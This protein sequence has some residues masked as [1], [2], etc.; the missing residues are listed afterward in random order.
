M[1]HFVYRVFSSVCFLVQGERNTNKLDKLYKSPLTLWTSPISR[2]NKHASGKCELHN[3]ALIAMENFLRNM[4][5]EAVPIHQQINNLLQRQISKNREI[6]KSLFKT[7]IF[8]QK[9]NI[10]LST[11]PTSSM[12]APNLN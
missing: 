2:F 1:V 8:C 7:V 10:A 4:R 12:V 9:N 11:S 3:L 5:R 6:L